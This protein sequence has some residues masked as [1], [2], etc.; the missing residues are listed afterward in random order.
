MK[1][2][3]IEETFESAVQNHKKNNF[4]IAEKLYKKILSVNP[5]HFRSIFLLGS[6]SAQ[7]KNLD[8]AKQLL[9]KAIQ[10]RKAIYKDSINKYLPYKQFINRYGNKYS[11]F[12]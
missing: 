10:I 2:E 4:K 8:S 3:N 12:D 9:Q 11:W 1:L 6:L 5:D 7:I